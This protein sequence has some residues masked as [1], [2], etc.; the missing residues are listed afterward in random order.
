MLH[1]ISSLNDNTQMAGMVLM[2]THCN[3]VMVS[4]IPFVN[5]YV[6]IRFRPIECVRMLSFQRHTYV[7][8]L[9]CSSHELIRLINGGNIEQEICDTLH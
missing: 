1:A 9:L 3:I 4:H 8:R 2:L 5:K 6:I 7:D